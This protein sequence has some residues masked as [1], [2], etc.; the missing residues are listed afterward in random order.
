MT[1]EQVYCQPALSCG[2][3]L[4]PKISILSRNIGHCLLLKVY[5]SK[6]PYGSLG[7]KNI[8]IF[9]ITADPYLCVKM[10]KLLN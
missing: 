6:I 8:K 1:N 5:F 10:L 2:G 7:E 9:N 3:P 4:R